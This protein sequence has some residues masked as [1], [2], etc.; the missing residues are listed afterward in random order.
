MLL[1]GDWVPALASVRETDP[2]WSGARAAYAARFPQ[3][4]SA[5]GTA[6]GASLPGTKVPSGRVLLPWGG[7]ADLP[8]VTA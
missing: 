2:G 3:A 7:L 1:A 4:G 8:S 5:A 6:R